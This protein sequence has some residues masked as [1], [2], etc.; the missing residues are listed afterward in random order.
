MVQH[1][2]KAADHRATP[3]LV[4][5]SN[6]QPVSCC[7]ISKHPSL[8]VRPTIPCSSQRICGIKL[9]VIA[10]IPGRAGNPGPFA[11][12]AL[13]LLNEEAH[14]DESWYK[15]RSLTYILASSL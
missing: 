14:R 3:L 2:C 10:G 7:N 8:T 9:K 12:W 15:V 6:L 13:Y 4:D 5:L 11:N 1:L